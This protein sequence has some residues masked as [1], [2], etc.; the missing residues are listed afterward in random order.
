[1]ANQHNE[2]DRF[3]DR[4]M[5][6]E[7]Y[8]PRRDR[9]RF[10]SEGQYGRRDFR[11]QEDSQWFETA[12]SPYRQYRRNQEGQGIWSDRERSEFSGGQ[13]RYNREPNR[14]FGGESE[15]QFERGYQPW[16]DPEAS[17]WGFKHSNYGP[18]QSPRDFE[19][20][21]EGQRF[22]QRQ[23]FSQ[24]QPATGQFAG[25]GPKGYR[26]SDERILDDINERLTQD[27]HIDASD[28]EVQVLNCEVTLLG[29]VDHREAKRRAEDIAESVFGINDVQNQIKVQNK[30]EESFDSDEV[31]GQYFGKESRKDKGTSNKDK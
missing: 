18:Y 28:I 10:R 30:N 2:R 5:E 25:R 22:G 4:D 16:V 23:S 27:P 9:E 26:R 6:Q 12:Q 7:D 20:R 15:R 17:R 3:N 24:G 29:T 19:N 21:F 14:R 11:D 13:E 31:T 1:M 8:F